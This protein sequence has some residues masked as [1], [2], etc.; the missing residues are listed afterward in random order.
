METQRME[1]QQSRPQQTELQEGVTTYDLLRLK[2]TAARCRLASLEM[3]YK[4]GSGHIPPDFSC[5]DIMVTL[6]FR[7][8]RLDPFRPDWDDR[9]RFILSKGHAVGALYVCLAER[10]FFPKEWLATYQQMKTRLPGHPDRTLTP[11]VEH[12]T[13]ALGH[14]LSVACGVAA[15]LRL[16]KRAW[17]ERLPRVYVLL[18][19]G[20]LQEG[21]N[22]EAAMFAAQQRLDN[23]IGIVDRN[24]LQQGDFTERTVALEDLEA[25]W[26][27]FG[28][29]VATCDGHDIHDLVD[30]LEKPPA[31]G[32]PRMIIAQTIKGR[33]GPVMEN[34][35][36]WHHRIPT[37][38]QYEA[39]KAGL[40][41]ALEALETEL[42]NEGRGSRG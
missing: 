27:S 11:G 36:Q 3:A 7:V 19:D 29:E 26:R 33:G 25:K 6:F 1:A 32:K 18:G 39:I 28:W 2:A 42:E 10:G 34:S 37:E 24:R 40:L 13:G 4:A 14:G 23:L 12:N 9:D 15:G 30:A 31:H 16:R 8:L 41:S 20:E 38:G 22:W 21:S 35:P 5:M 17:S